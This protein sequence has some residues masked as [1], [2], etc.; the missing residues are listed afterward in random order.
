MASVPNSLTNLT[1]IQWVVVT[2][3]LGL[4]VVDAWVF[5]SLRE[6]TIIPE[7]TLVREAV[8]DKPDL[9]LLD[10]LLDRVEKLLLGDLNASPGS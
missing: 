7:I 4:R 10:V 3:S 8:A 1:D 2:L 9:A 5:P 6:C